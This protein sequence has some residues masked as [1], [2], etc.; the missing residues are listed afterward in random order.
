MLSYK[1]LAIVGFEEEN[2]RVRADNMVAKPS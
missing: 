1:T 2:L